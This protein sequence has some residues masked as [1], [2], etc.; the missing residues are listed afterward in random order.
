M[1]N[2]IKFFKLVKFLAKLT[3]NPSMNDKKKL[4]EK[5]NFYARKKKKRFE[6]KN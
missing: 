2:N 4:I 5:K 1:L 3:F 6:V